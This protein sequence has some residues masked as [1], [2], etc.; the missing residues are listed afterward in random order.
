V[1]AARSIA[2]N[3]RLAYTR[4]NFARTPHDPSSS[5]HRPTMPK[6]DDIKCILIIGAGPI[7]IGQACEFD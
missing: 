3:R 6:R 7:V 5:E 2:P 4:P 1:T